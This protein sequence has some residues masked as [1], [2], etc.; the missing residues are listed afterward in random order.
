MGQAK[1]PRSKCSQLFSPY[2][3]DCQNLRLRYCA[4]SEHGAP[5][6]R[7][8]PAALSAD[9]DLTGYENLLLSGKLYGL[10]HQERETRIAEVLDFMGLTEYSQKT[11][12]QYSGG[13]IRRLEIA[14]A[15]LHEPGVLFLDEPTV[16]L[17]PAARKALWQRIQEWRGSSGRQF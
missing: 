5:L 14:Q 3:R 9:G 15:L 1:A 6:F 8:R 2:V 4:K 12:N 17:D 13:M 10:T 7:V 11:V 16:G